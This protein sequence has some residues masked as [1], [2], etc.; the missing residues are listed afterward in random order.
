[1]TSDRDLGCRTPY[2]GLSGQ[3]VTRSRSNV[4]YLDRRS[5]AQWLRIW[6]YQRQ[7]GPFDLLYVNSVWQPVF[8]L[9]PVMAAALRLVAVRRVLIAP[10]GEFSP[11]ALGIRS[12]KKRMFLALWR[13]VLDR[14]DVVW[15]ASNDREAT[16]IQEL[17]GATRIVVRENETLLPADPTPPV[18]HGAD[19]LRLVFLSRITPMK[20]LDLVLRALRSVTGPLTLDI[21][22]PIDDPPYWRECQR[23]CDDL[24][25]GTRVRYRGVLRPGQVR[26]T[27]ARYDALVLPTRGENFG[28]VIAESLSASCAVICSADTPWTEV[29]TG[30]GGVVL[31][32]TS[33]AELI[34][35]IGDMVAGGP[36]EWW[37]Q[38][39]RAGAAYRAWRAADDKP[40]VLDLVRAEAFVGSPGRATGRVYR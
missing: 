2:P 28:H 6:R 11:G 21:Y 23:L 13:R 19:H 16:Q 5:P 26:E 37:N 40:G 7:A 12:R 33:A 24:A 18:D 17:V 36:A 39:V 32:E 3:W 9:L 29:L 10:R 38:R 15:H 34:R 31:P 8:S 25:P 27:L 22:G 1:M 30:G 35:V 20:N 4:F 14:L